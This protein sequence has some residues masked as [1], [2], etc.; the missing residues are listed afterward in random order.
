M[1]GVSTPQ[2]P[3]DDR[4]AGSGPERPQ[5]PDRPDA[6][7][8]SRRSTGAAVVAALL[9]LAISA[10]LIISVPAAF[11]GPDDEAA[12]DPPPV[13]VPAQDAP[14]GPLSQQTQDG[15]R[16]A[17][18]GSSSGAS[19]V[20][21][22]DPASGE[23]LFS[24]GEGEALVPA[25]NQKILTHFSLLHHTGPDQ[26]LATTTVAGQSPNDVVLVAGGD[27]L[28]APG[29]GDPGAVTGR[30]G[31][32]D[33]AAS[34]ADAMGE[35]LDPGRP[36]RVSRDTSIFSGPALNPAWAPGDIEAQEIGEI[37]PMAFG[38]HHVPGQEGAYDPDP[39]GSVAG[40]F[41]DELERE[42]AERTG[43]DVQVEPGDDVDTAADP[44]R[45]ADQQEGV[46]E[47][48]RVESAPSR[49]RPGG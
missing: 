13:A 46:A 17:I 42:L 5:A 49:S 18:D 38:S 23:V 35:D 28:L 12:V 27:T 40:A 11:G 19:G 1:G 7:R 31:I 33:L 32:A 25:S 41:E 21:V 37:S 14:G 30:A 10:S 16:A 20:L 43:R 2:S 15:I 36:V 44:L 22:L 39:V 45:P 24:E 34:T 47:L 3:R 26:R 9:V 6:P 48:A 8:R 29:E 4:R